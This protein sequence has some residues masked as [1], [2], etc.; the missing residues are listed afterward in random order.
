MRRKFF[1]VTDF[2]AELGL[3]YSAWLDAEEVKSRHHERIPAAHPDKPGGGVPMASRLNEARRVLESHSRR[4]R[5]LLELLSPEFT[6]ANKAAPDWE[7]FST[8]GE[9]AREASAIA[10]QLSQASS[11]I[12]R[13]GLLAKAK[14]CEQRLS[15]AKMRLQDHRARLEKQTRCLQITPLDSQKTWSLAEAWTFHD[16]LSTTLREAETA[17]KTA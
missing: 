6:P 10:A 2:F 3:P 17:L 4:L 7:L 8:I 5:H 14:N 15:A 11:P 12:V 9:A 16:R 13:A 1:R